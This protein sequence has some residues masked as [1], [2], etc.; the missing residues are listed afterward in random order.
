MNRRGLI[1]L[2][3]LAL[4]VPSAAQATV[5]EI[6]GHRPASCPDPSVTRVGASAYMVCTSDSA[7]NAFPIY[8]SQDRALGSWQRIGY[9][10]PKGHQPWWALRSPAGHYWSP[11][12]QRIGGSWVVYFAAQINRAKYHRGSLIGPHTFG[13]GVAWAPSLHGPWRTRLLH[14]RGQFNHWNRGTEN[15]GGVIDPG[16]YRDPSS[17]QRYLVWAE[18][19]SSVW[20][21]PLY[22]NGLAIEGHHIH[23]LFY[24]HE[25]YD[26]FSMSC[27]NEGPAPFYRDGYFYIFYSVRSTWNWSYAMRVAYSTNPMRGYHTEPGFILKAGNGWFGPGGGQAPVLA[28]DGQWLEFYHASRRTNTKHTSALRYLLSDV[29]HWHVQAADGPAAPPAGGQSDQDVAQGAPPAVPIP[30]IGTGI[31]G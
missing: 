13:L 16:E 25:P 23:M 17:G 24:A 7:E 5:V 4:A 8:R 29:V 11:S 2:A 19:P 27:V 6:G 20:A 18:Q 12:I 22:Q 15:Y 9:V 30:V 28:P 26:C 10:L 3:L 14:Y 21:A 1:M 31:V